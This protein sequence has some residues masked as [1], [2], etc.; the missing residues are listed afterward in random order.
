MGK[1][2]N[3][4][5]YILSVCGCFIFAYYMNFNAPIMWGTIMAIVLVIVINKIGLC[6]EKSNVVPIVFFTVLLSAVIVLGKHININTENLYSGNVDTSYISSYKFYDIIAWLLMAY[7]FAVIIC[8]LYRCKINKAWLN[9]EVN[10]EKK[11]SCKTTI[12]FMCLFFLAWLPYLL[13]YFPGFYFGDSVGSVAQAIGQTPLNNH[14]PVIYAMLIRLC[15]WI[16]GGKTAVTA[17]IAIYC[18]VQM[19]YMSFV[20]GYF[21][22]WL[23]V[24][25]NI[26][27]IVLLFWGILLGTSPYIAQFS[28][29][30]W[31]DPIF[32]V[33]IVLA[34]M[35]LYEIFLKKTD[36]KAQII[37]SIE[38][39][40]SLFVVNFSRN[41]GLYIVLVI[42]LIALLGLL[43]KDIRTVAIK[44]IIVSVS[45]I[46]L[47][48]VITGPVYNS[49]GVIQDDK[50]AESYGIFL[51]QMAR[52]V[53]LRGNLSESD[54]EY[55]N[56]VLPLDEYEKL[57]AP[58]C[59]DNLK[60]S[61]E[62]NNSALDKD[63]FKTY[64]SIL[65]KNPKI[66]FE[67]WEFQTF[68]FWTLNQ[69][70][71]NYYD[72]NISAGVP[73]NIYPNDLNEI[74]NL[75]IKKVDVS[76]KA[77]NLFPYTGNF[78]PVAYAN[79]LLIAVAIFSLFK[80]RLDDLIV[81]APALGLMAT[82][83][84]ASPIFYW[85]RYGFAEQLLIPLFIV[86]FLRKR[87]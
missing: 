19:L 38:L 26:N 74:D 22:N 69:K 75:K 81:V 76:S 83:I 2:I 39:F 77:V 40:I 53:T 24:R 84:I 9:I 80:L 34:S 79:W 55:M 66:C 63:F 56:A 62:F 44:I 14:H 29:T 43:R 52:V 58:G 36:K 13:V 70:I 42:F 86:I 35:L 12:L 20:L 27:K 78:I 25:F 51:S 72:G 73:R 10:S 7:L 82:L 17:G 47:N 49:I 18:I 23:R 37:I 8:I 4:F 59:I 50:K 28:V 33:S 11:I 65:K 85:P 30:V 46:V 16:A 64:F 32:S 21:I 45:I 3:I 41:N 5:R 31:K 60:W 54:K 71:I 67:A 87:K 1:Q 68:G 61:G 48:S 57:Y 6:R 15:I